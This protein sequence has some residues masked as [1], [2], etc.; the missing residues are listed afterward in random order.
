MPGGHLVAAGLGDEGEGE[1]GSFGG[2]VDGEANVGGERCGNRVGK[3]LRKR[4]V[5][6]GMPGI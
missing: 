3:G 5:R 4:C 6:L 1:F 2:G